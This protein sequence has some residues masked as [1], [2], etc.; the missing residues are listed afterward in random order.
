M[1]EAFV[2][3]TD[4]SVEDVER[5]KQEARLALAARDA[6]LSKPSPQTESAI[7]GALHILPR[8]A[9]IASGIQRKR[10]LTFVEARQKVDSYYEGIKAADLL[11]LQRAAKAV[12]EALVALEAEVSARGGQ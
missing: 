2:V 5:V 6:D 12:R 10:E 9:E 7:R 3:K 8:A 1:S 4:S 11:D